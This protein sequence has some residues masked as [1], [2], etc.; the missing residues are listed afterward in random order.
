[1]FSNLARFAAECNAN[2]FDVVPL[3]FLL[4][5]GTLTSPGFRS[6]LAFHKFISS[7][8]ADTKPAGTPKRGRKAPYLPRVSRLRGGDPARPQ[9]LEDTPECFRYRIP[10]AS[11]N[12][13]DASA[14]GGIWLLKPA[15]LSR[16]RGLSWKIHYL[17]SL[18][19]FNQMIE[20]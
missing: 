4:E 13:E 8:E 2:V 20:L 10:T 14:G 6:F 18:R 16:G 5:N 11:M 17:I 15:A 9:S 1:M 7:K 12:L 19:I 3:T